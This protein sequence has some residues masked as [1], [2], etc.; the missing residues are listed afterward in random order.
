[1]IWTVAIVLLSLW[2]LGTS[3]ALGGGIH[4]L[5]AA[6]VLLTVVGVIRSRRKS[7]TPGSA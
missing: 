3:Y 5:L 2:M 7:Q 6:V 1:M 4:I